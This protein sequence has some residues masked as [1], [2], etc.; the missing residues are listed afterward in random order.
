[1]KR[2]SKNSERVDQHRQVI[3]INRPFISSQ[4][5]CEQCVE[6]SGMITPEE[7]AALSNVSTRSIYRWLESGSIHFSETSSRG[8]LIC[9][10]TL[11]KN[12]SLPV[13]HSQANLRINR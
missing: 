11:A 5:R 12:I 13:R 9:L 7:A 4:R 8:L 6:R 3:I 10:R 2:Q 1:M